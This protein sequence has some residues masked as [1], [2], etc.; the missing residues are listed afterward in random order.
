MEKTLETLGEATC[1]YVWIDR[2]SVPQ[3]SSELQNTL[4]S[5]MMGV[6]A[7]ARETLILRT[8]EEDGSR[9]HQRAW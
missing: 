6:F 8:Q 9:Y 2:I 1:L 7:T 4:L 3:G 5:R